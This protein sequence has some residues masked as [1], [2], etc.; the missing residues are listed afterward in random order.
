[1][2]RKVV[3]DPAPH[4]FEEDGVTAK[5]PFGLNVD[6]SPRKS[7]RG[8]RAGQRGMKPATTSKADATRRTSLIQLV[9][10]LIVVPLAGASVAPP[11]VA[12]MGQH[13]ADALGAD[14]Y[15]IHE[16][17]PALADG[18]IVLSQSKPGV[19]SWLDSAEQNAP[20]LAIMMASVQLGMA[21]VA[22]HRAPNVE[23]ANA[24]RDF[25]GAGPGAK[26]AQKAA[27]QSYA[28]QAAQDAQE[29][30]QVVQDAQD[31]QASQAV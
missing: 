24:A 7:N 13:Q 12:R 2:P 29:V 31:A 1:M 21:L 22:N 23:M 25:I 27:E 4:G 6:G 8:A 20:Y 10:A 3:H 19:L 5:A 28:A 11:V 16:H 17:T 9:D 18:L 26:A 15:S 14:A 30:T